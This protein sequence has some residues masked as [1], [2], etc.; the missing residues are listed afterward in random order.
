MDID[1]IFDNWYI[2]DE[3]LQI[4]DERITIINNLEVGDYIGYE[5][6]I[7]EILKKDYTKDWYITIDIDGENYPLKGYNIYMGYDKIYK[8]I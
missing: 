2:D 3:D 8:I 5:N 1:K 6:E 4:S 7:Y